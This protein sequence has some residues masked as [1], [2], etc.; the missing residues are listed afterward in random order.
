[1]QMGAVAKLVSW[2]LTVAASAPLAAVAQS[3]PAAFFTTPYMVDIRASHGSIVDREAVNV[4]RWGP[5]L[6]AG[7]GSWRDGNAGDATYAGASFRPFGNDTDRDLVFRVNYLNDNGIRQSEAQG[8]YI[9]RDGVG[10]GLGYVEGLA[11]SR[12]LYFTKFIYRKKH[13]D[14]NVYLSPQWQRNPDKND[15]GGYFVLSTDEVFMSAGTDGEQWRGLL[16]VVTKRRER[17]L[18]RPVG[19]ILYVDNSLGDRD[20]VKF[21][22]INGSLRF[23]GGFMSPQSRLG[24]ALGPSGNH[25]GN[26]LSFLSQ[27]W[28]RTA[29]VWEI[30]QL[31]NMRI[32]RAEFPNRQEVEIFETVVFPTQ[33]VRDGSWA[34]GLFLGFQNRNFRFES[35]TLQSGK[36]GM[37]GYNRQFS[38]VL[39]ATRLLRNF[40]L[41]SNELVFTFKYYFFRN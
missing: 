35:G 2:T 41:S 34:N 39:I 12:D 22:F 6:N 18:L 4:A 8:Q 33:F 30:G 9:G 17:A 16:G 38:Q 3:S 11:N 13:G 15:L 27:S 5:N 31:A 14:W 19:E 26:A 37:I 24:R 25:F 36:A 20:D 28:N 23:D 40:A 7:F 32:I 21:F 10:F 1:M 29:D